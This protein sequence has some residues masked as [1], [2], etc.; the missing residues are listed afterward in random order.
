MFTQVGVGGLVVCYAI[1][2]AF[3]FIHIETTL[4][5]KFETEWNK[6]LVTPD[7]NLKGAWIQLAAVERLTT[8]T[9]TKLWEFTSSENVFN[10]TTWKA[11]TDLILREFQV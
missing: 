11:A 5:P 4:D 1:V 3:G 10:A 9:A 2:G 6:A 7:H 8:E